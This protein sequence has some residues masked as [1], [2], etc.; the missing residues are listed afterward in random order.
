[1]RDTVARWTAALALHQL[2]DGTPAPN[3]GAH[4][5]DFRRL[6]LARDTQ[7]MMTTHETYERYTLEEV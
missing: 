4:V 2:P 7:W 3:V 1:M 5:G 6:E